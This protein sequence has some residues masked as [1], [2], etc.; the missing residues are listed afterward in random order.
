MEKDI[1]CQDSRSFWYFD[2]IRLQ[3][4]CVSHKPSTIAGKQF[5][6]CFCMGIG[7]IAMCVPGLLVQLQ[8]WRAKNIKA[9]ASACSQ[10]VFLLSQ[11]NLSNLAAESNFIYFAK[12]CRGTTVIS[13]SAA[14]GSEPPPTE[15]LFRGCQMA[16][17][18]AL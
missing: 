14:C 16:A 3:S 13:F 2:A 12:H 17:G 9:M 8:H 1:A 6:P 11:I 4:L 5:L 10:A 18:R 7:N 15:A